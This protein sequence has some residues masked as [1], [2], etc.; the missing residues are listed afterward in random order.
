MCCLA[1]LELHMMTDEI[2]NAF[3][4]TPLPYPW[5]VKVKWVKDS[6]LFS[7]PI[8]TM[9][10]VSG[11]VENVAELIMKYGWYHLKKLETHEEKAR[12]LKMQQVRMGIL[13]EKLYVDVAP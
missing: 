10:I 4:Q 1:G 13:R 8:V 9:T 3:E 2:A 11:Q 7:V 5:N 6:E 12:R